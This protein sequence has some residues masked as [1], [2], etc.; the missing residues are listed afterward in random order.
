MALSVAEAPAPAMTRGAPGDR[1]DAQF[2]DP[3]VLIGDTRGALAGRAD[4][5]DAVNPARNLAFRSGSERR[6]R[7]LFRHERV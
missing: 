2:D 1:F 6:I 7:P 3:L 5:D 4:R